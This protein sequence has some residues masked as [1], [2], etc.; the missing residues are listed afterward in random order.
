M[1]SH[2]DLNYELGAMYLPVF[3][4]KKVAEQAVGLVVQ[5]AMSMPAQGGIGLRRLQWSTQEKNKRSE[6]LAE[7][8]GFEREGLQKYLDEQ[9]AGQKGDARMWPLTRATTE[10]DDEIPR[11]KRRGRSLATRIKACPGIQHDV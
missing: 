3:W 1:Y 8:L 11:W 9:R 7:K 6:G 2:G 4:G 5:W 10:T